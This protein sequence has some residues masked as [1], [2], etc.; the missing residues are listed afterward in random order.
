MND[1]Y[2]FYKTNPGFKKYVDAVAKDCEET[3]ENML[4]YAIVKEVYKY[5]LKESEKGKE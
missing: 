2:E 4:E 5:Y 3:P 1:I